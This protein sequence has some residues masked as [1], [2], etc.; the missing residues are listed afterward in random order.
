[1]GAPHPTVGDIASWEFFSGSIL[2]T[3]R[4]LTIITPL[5]WHPV[6]TCQ[7]V[8]LSPPGVPDHYEP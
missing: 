1:M 7:P 5:V 4:F 3:A 6:S 8:S 2:A